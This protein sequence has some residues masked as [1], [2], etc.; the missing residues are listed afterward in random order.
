VAW[1]SGGGESGLGPALA[2]R[3]WSGGGAGVGHRPGVEANMGRRLAPEV[4]SATVGPQ[5]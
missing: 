2:R 4:E 3:A 5:H 1:A